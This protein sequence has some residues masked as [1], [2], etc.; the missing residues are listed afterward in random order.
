MNLHQSYPPLLQI[1]LANGEELCLGRR[2]NSM[3]IDLLRRRIA[4]IEDH[5]WRDRE[6]AAQLAAL[7][8]VSEQ[9]SE[10]TASH[11]LVM[12]GQ[13]RHFLANSSFQKALAHLES[14]A[15]SEI[16]ASSPEPK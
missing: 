13:L 10:W 15:G 1:T 9:I 12:D 6:P 7:Q 5:A 4:V 3:L 8:A 16:S 11:R 2:V 14:L